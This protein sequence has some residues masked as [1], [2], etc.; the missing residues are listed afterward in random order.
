MTAWQDIVTAPRN[1]TL[2][3][4]YCPWVDQVNTG[5]Y[6]ANGLGTGWRIWFSQRDC[7]L[8]AGEP[9]HW[10]PL[11]PRPWQYLPKRRGN[12]YAERRPAS[13]P[14]ELLGGIQHL[15]LEDVDRS[16]A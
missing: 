4:V 3:L 1:G 8:V 11:P 13:E 12:S 14:G 16:A 7:P 10:M 6:L 2:V 9:S 5:K 15:T